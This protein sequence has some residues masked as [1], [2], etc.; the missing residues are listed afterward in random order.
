MDLAQFRHDMLRP[1]H[2]LAPEFRDVADALAEQQE[3]HH[4][5]ERL[6]AGRVLDLGNGPRVML[7]G[8]ISI[9]SVYRLA[10][11]G[12]LT[13]RPLE[14]RNIGRH[15]SLIALVE[16]AAVWT[17]EDRSKARQKALG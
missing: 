11:K 9:P 14:G 15:A 10:D 12:R 1:A 16:T 3:Q 8:G 5:E 13:L 17:P 2:M 7:C 6:G 4:G